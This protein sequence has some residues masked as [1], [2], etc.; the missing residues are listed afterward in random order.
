MSLMSKEE[1]E[2]T[3][4]SYDEI[5]KAFTGCREIWLVLHKS[6]VKPSKLT[7]SCFLPWIKLKP[8]HYN[9]IYSAAEFNEMMKS[10]YLIRYSLVWEKR[11]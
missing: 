7:M 3:Y 9:I 10:P 5:V 11:G 8:S 2:S 1:I 4:N 6:S